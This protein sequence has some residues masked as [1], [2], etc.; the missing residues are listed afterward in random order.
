MAVTT[1]KIAGTRNAIR[2]EANV[3]MF[4]D[5]MREYIC[6]MTNC[7]TPAPTLAHPAATPLASPTTHPENMELIQN[8][9][10]TKFA[11]QN[12]TRKRTRINDVG[13]VTKQVDKMT[14]AVT[15]ESVAEAMR[16]PTRSQAGP[17]ARREKMEPMKEAMP[18]LPMSVSVR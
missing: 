10:A 5:T 16:G 17:M 2:Q 15:R 18:A 13:E 6:G 12:P 8:W 7:A 3:G 4:K 14:G 9:F 11:R 1:W